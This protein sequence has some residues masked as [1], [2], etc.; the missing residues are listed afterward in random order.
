MIF[1][2][3]N[4]VDEFVDAKKRYLAFAK[5]CP[6][7]TFSVLKMFSSSKSMLRFFILK[8]WHP[9][10]FPFTHFLGPK[11]IFA[12]LLLDCAPYAPT[13]AFKFDRQRVKTNG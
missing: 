10:Y 9:F 1:L 13:D 3:L 7:W 5:F 8:W 12:K 2:S 11:A 6:M 4:Y